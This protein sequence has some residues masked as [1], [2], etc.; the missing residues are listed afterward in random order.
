[1]RDGIAR[2]FAFGE[3][4]T[5]LMPTITAVSAVAGDA[6]VLFWSCSLIVAA[7]DAV[8][9]IASTVDRFSSSCRP[10]RTRLSAINRVVASCCG[11]SWLWLLRYQCHPHCTEELDLL[12]MQSC[13]RI[14]LWRLCSL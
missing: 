13:P 3:L 4:V 14:A 6:I 11:C 12:A 5:L 10:P 7:S 1:M 9:S 8:F 2:I